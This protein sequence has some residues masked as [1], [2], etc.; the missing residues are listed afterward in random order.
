MTKNIS[1]TKFQTVAQVKYTR[2]VICSNLGT[3]GGKRENLEAKSRTTVNEGNL[4]A[5]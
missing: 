3:E 2:I 1:E 5:S 4:R